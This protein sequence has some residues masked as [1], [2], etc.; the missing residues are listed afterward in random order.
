M[1]IRSVIW[2]TI[3]TIY[4]ICLPYSSGVFKSIVLSLAS[5][6]ALSSSTPVRIEPYEGR[7]GYTKVVVYSDGVKLDWVAKQIP[8]QETVSVGGRTIKDDT[9]QM[10]Y[11]V[12]IV[13]QI[14]ERINKK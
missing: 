7:N 4:S 9:K 10:E 11:I 3:E 2:F 8:E 12:S 6:E 14:T 5:D 1:F 13:N